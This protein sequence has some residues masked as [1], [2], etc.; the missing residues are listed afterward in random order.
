MKRFKIK[1]LITGFEF[2]HEGEASPPYNPTWGKP[3]RWVQER[4]E[5]ITN[6]TEARTGENGII[7]YKLPAE[8]TI[9]EEN[10]DAE[11]AAKQTK[12]TQFRNVLASYRDQV[13]PGMTV[14]QRDQFLER[15]RQIILRMANIM[16][17]QLENAD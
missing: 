4:D 6:S 13:I 14:A 9:T 8:Y 17:N 5:D 2:L 12:I 11:I 16:L 7:E 10:I 15:Q 3:E 1:N